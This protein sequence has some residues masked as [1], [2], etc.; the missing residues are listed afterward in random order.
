MMSLSNFLAIVTITTKSHNEE[1]KFTTKF[2]REKSCDV[3]SPDVIATIYNDDKLKLTEL[4][5]SLGR[6]D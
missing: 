2:W 5:T 6:E 4:V 3:P 1:Q